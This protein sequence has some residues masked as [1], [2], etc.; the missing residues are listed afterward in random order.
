MRRIGVLID[1]CR[2][3]SGNAKSR[4]LAFRQRNSNAADGRKG[5]N[6]HID[7]RSA[8]GNADQHRH[9]SLRKSCSPCNPNVILAHSTPMLPK[10]CSRKP[11]RSRSCSSPFPTLSDQ[12]SSPA[13][14]VPAEISPACYSIEEGIAGKWLAMLKEIAPNLARAALIAN[15]KT[16]PYRLLPAVRPKPLR[17]VAGDRAGA[18]LTWRRP[19]TLS[20]R[21]LPSR[22]VPDGGLVLPPDS[23]T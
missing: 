19:P 14:R 18:Q 20:A 23:T 3:R 22:A 6:V 15:P 4:L 10:R 17:I 21:S 2:G 5:R 13:W 16:T 12:A 7:I 11:T 8:A 9:R 1:H